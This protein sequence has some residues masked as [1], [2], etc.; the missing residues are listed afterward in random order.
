MSVWSAGVIRNAGFCG[1]LLDYSEASGLRAFGHGMY[2]TVGSG[3]G[4][5]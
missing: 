2:N 3:K 5:S 4:A 1:F